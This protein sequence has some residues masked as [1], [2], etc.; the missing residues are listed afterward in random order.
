MIVEVITSDLR[1]SLHT[2]II[3]PHKPVILTE[4]ITRF[5]FA[6]CELCSKRQFGVKPPEVRQVFEFSGRKS[7]V[8]ILRR[9]PIIVSLDAKWP[10]A[11]FHTLMVYKYME[12]EGKRGR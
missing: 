10:L 9:R 2:D 6:V 5:D 7:T 11:T 12:E 1:F 3:L 8:F 4:T